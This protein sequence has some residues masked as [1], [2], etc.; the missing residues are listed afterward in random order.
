MS[1]WASI[2]RWMGADRSTN[3]KKSKSS[4]KVFLQLRQMSGPPGPHWLGGRLFRLQPS[5]HPPS[6]TWPEL[7]SFLFLASPSSYFNPNQGD[8]LAVQNSTIG[9]LVRDDLPPKNM[10]TFGH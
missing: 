4:K 10:F 9:D 5:I 2:I 6:S 8:F 3:N 1:M 7:H